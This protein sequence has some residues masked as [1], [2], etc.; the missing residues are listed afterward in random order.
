MTQ[1]NQKIYYLFQP[2]AFFF[3]E[4]QYRDKRLQSPYIQFLLFETVT[5]LVLMLKLTVACKNN[6]KYPNNSNGI[7][8]QT[9]FNQD[10]RIKERFNNKLHLKLFYF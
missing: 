10:L 2:L 9:L 1:H 4:Q 5:F 7:S 6:N 8:R 3:I